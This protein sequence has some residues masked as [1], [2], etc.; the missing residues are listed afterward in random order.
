M[1]FATICQKEKGK[2]E[3]PLAS[4]LP[5]ISSPENPLHWLLCKGRWLVR[6]WIWW[7]WRIR[8]FWCRITAAASRPT[9]QCKHIL[10]FNRN[11]MC[12][13]QASHSKN[14]EEDRNNP[15][16]RDLHTV[17]RLN[18]RSFFLGY[19]TFSYYKSYSI[20]VIHFLLAQD[21]CYHSV[22]TRLRKIIN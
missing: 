7:R 3:T 16:C 15:D 11:R 6:W 17:L 14:H 22:Y 9:C 12:N 18:A 5:L 13:T 4:S 21:Y 8:W 2:V 19:L 20:F 10:L 1:N